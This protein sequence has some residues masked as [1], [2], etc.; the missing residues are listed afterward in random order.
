M[1]MMTWI[2][3]HEVTLLVD[4]G[5]SHNFINTNILRKVRLARAAVGP[6]E[7]KVT[8]GEYLRCEDVREMKMN[9]QRVRIVVDLHILNLVEQDVVLENAWLGTLGRVT[10]DYDKMTM[11]F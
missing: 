9:V 7:V 4:N 3:K 8:N 10:S 1:R 6:F 5:S 2:D 11:E